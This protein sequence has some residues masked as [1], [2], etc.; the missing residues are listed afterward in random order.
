M[1]S[2]LQF[3]TDGVI[4]HNLILFQGLGVYALLRFTKSIGTAFKSSV[5]MLVSTL[6]ACALVWLAEPLIPTHFGMQLPAY[7]AIAL[8]SGLL[9]NKVLAQALALEPEQSLLTAF[10]NSA[11]IGVL[12]GIPQDL[13]AGAAIVGYGAACAVGYGLVLIVM[14]GI[15]ERLALANVP[16]PFRGVPILLISAALLALAL[17]GYRL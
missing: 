16:K 6:T 5:M 15:R 14:A 4:T 11:L 1:N 7:L 8:A 17:M 10:I 9:W 2:S 12:L 3:L 13:P